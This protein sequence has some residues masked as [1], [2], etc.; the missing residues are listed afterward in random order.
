MASV[1]NSNPISSCLINLEPATTLIAKRS[2]SCFRIKNAEAGFVQAIFGKF[3]ENIFL[4]IGES[5]QA[6]HT[7]KI[8]VSFPSLFQNELKKLD[9][10]KEELSVLESKDWVLEAQQSTGMDPSAQIQ[11]YKKLVKYAE[12]AFQSFPTE[13]TVNDMGKK[14]KLK[15]KCTEAVVQLRAVWGAVIVEP[16]ITLTPE[17]LK[18]LKISHESKMLKLTELDGPGY[19]FLKVREAE[20]IDWIKGTP[21]GMYPYQQFY[22]N[23]LQSLSRW[24]YTQVTVPETNDLVVYFNKGVFQHIGVFTDKGRVV[25]KMGINE[26]AITDHEIHHIPGQYGR[27]ILFFRKQIKGDKNESCNPESI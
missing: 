20:A 12:T 24:R 22:M 23:P 2:C 10:Y 27:E 4:K 14:G 7:T 6:S 17:D 16:T 25:S 26:P 15:D 11:A 21:I 8:K 9:G 3:L 13:V 1:S 19:A 5:F 18:F